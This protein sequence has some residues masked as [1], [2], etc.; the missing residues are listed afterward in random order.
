MNWP[1]WM[2][3]EAAA[4][5]DEASRW[6]DDKRQGLG[7]EFLE[8]IDAALSHIA[9]WPRTG[10][11]VPL[12]AQDVAVRQVPAGRFPYHVVYFEMPTVIRILAFAHGRR[13]PRYW[14]DR[15]RE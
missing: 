3:P 10:A 2:E 13:K 9:R 4:E 5:L 12:V 11:P 1:I 14:H 15:I 6:Y 7:T 8:A